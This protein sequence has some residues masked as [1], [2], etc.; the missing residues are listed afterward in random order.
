MDEPKPAFCGDCLG[1]EGPFCVLDQPPGLG[2]HELLDGVVRLSA[3][4][5]ALS[6]AEERMMLLG[7]GK[8]AEP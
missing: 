2:T 3:G 5:T 4:V 8:A 7:W 1:W 6:L